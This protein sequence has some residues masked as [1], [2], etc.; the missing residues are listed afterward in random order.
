MNN[1]TWTTTQSGSATVIA[2]SRYAESLARALTE[3]PDDSGEHGH[4]GGRGPVRRVELSDGVVAVVRRFRRGGVVRHFLRDAYLLHNRPLQE[5][6]ATKRI[7]AMGLP[8][9][10]PLGVMW[11]GSGPIYRGSIATACVYGPTLLEELKKGNIREEQLV[12]VGETI[13]RFHDCCVYH[14]DLNAANIILSPTGTAIIDWDRSEIRDRPSPNRATR[15]LNRLL[16]SLQKH[17]CPGAFKAIVHGYTAGYES[18]V[19]GPLHTW[20]NVSPAPLNFAAMVGTDGE[21]I[22]SSMKAISRRVDSYYVKHTPLSVSSIA[23]CMAKPGHFR[24]NFDAA[25]RMKRAGIATPVPV[26][27]A[28]RR[29]GPLVTQQAI[30]T[31]WADGVVNVEEFARSL[32]GDNADDEAIAGY[33]S[34]LASAV[35]S[36]AACG[37]H[38]A[39]LSGKNVL[40]GDGSSFIFVDLDSVRAGFGMD[41]ADMFKRDVQLYDSFCD[42]WGPEILD[43]FIAGIHEPDVLPAGWVDRVREG[44]ARRRARVEAIWAQK[45]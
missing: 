43:P 4:V 41:E 23:R 28:E 31:E 25:L 36:L 33:L 19:D 9:A 16:R 37:I 30:A 7:A 6:E 22:K 42:F 12:A 40:T 29:I 18:Q 35:Q 14:A 39:D 5:W 15:N 8:I 26:V 2:D 17:G 20:S 32:V 44:Q 11:R 21:V 34:R 10:Q 27:Y 45:G 24:M 13:A 3:P 1:D 38:H